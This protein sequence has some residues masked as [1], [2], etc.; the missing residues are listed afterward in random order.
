[1][2]VID[3]TAKKNSQLF[4]EATKKALLLRGKKGI[5]DGFYKV[6]GGGD[7]LDFEEVGIFSFKDISQLEFPQLFDAVFVKLWE[8]LLDITDYYRLM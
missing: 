6:I 7:I 8:V 4:E 2:T 3:L 1:M 5:E